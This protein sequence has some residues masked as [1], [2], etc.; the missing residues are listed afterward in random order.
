VYSA[1]LRQIAKK[2]EEARF[3]KVERGKFTTRG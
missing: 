1:I 2:G 3:V